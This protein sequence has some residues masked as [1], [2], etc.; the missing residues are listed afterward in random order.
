MFLAAEALEIGSCWI[1]TVNFL[2]GTEEGKALFKE[3]GIPEGYLLR[4][5]GAFGYILGEKPAPAP[6]REGTV[7]I[8]R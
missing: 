5:S 4:A 7:H 2:A 3:L 6:R 1:H 8:I